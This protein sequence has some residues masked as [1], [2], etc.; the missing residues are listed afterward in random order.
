M[1][2]LI[3]DIKTLGAGV[4][5]FTQLDFGMDESDWCALTGASQGHVVGWWEGKVG[6]VDFPATTA[7]EVVWLAEG[8]I[9]LT[10]AQGG[11]REFAAGDAYFVQAGFAGRWETL[12][13]AKKLYV[14]L[15][16]PDS[17]LKA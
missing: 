9:A 16:K 3:Q 15:E 2:K 8:R 4:G 5:S 7:D 13:D 12:E 6:A 1:S 17:T 14:L 11:R 10:D